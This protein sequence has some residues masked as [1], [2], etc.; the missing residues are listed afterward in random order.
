MARTLRNAAI[1]T[2]TA[3]SKLEGRR[4]PYYLKIQDGLHLG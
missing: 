3:R 2:R 4:R 1:E